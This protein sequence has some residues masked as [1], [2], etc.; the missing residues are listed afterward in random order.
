MGRLGGAS[1]EVDALLV[2][3]S[4]GHSTKL[5]GS[6]DQDMYCA[7]GPWHLG[8]VHAFYVKV[9]CGIL[10]GIVDFWKRRRK[11]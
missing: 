3:G 7:L 2:Y 10:S 1:S 5:C 4:D 9:F 8:L 6:T 11:F